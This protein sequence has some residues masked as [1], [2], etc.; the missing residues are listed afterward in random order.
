MFI[1]IH[2][3]LTGIYLCV[4]FGVTGRVD[5]NLLLIGILGGALIDLDKFIYFFIRKD[6]ISLKCRSAI[7]NME[8]QK[9]IKLVK[10][11]RKDIH[12]LFLHN[13]FFQTILAFLS[14]YFSFSGNL[15]LGIFFTSML[16]HTI[17]DI[18]DDFLVL[19]N[20]SNWLWVSK[21]KEIK[22]IYL[23]IYLLFIASCFIYSTLQIILH[24]S[25]LG[26]VNILHLSNLTLWIY[27]FFVTI[28]FM[29]PFLSFMSLYKF[30]K[31]NI[32][33]LI[34]LYLKHDS[35][36]ET[37]KNNIVLW[38][39][40]G[41]VLLFSILSLVGTSNEIYFF[42]VVVGVSAFFAIMIHPSVGQFVGVYGTSAVFIISALQQGSSWA[43]EHA[44]L[45]LIITAVAWVFSIVGGRIVYGMIK[46]SYSAFVIE[47]TA[48]NQSPKKIFNDLMLSKK[49]LK[50][51]YRKAHKETYNVKKDFRVAKFE[52][53]TTM[54]VCRTQGVCHMNCLI[55]F[56]ISDGYIPAL[57][58][59]GYIFWDQPPIFPRVRK[60]TKVDELMSGDYIYQKGKYMRVRD[61][62]SIDPFKLGEV[63][64]IDL[65]NEVISLFK[66]PSQVLDHF[67]N[68]R[69]SFDTDLYIYNISEI[70]KKDERFIV[71]GITH[72]HTS[73]KEYLTMESEIYSDTVLKEINAFLRS[74]EEKECIT[75]V[76]VLTGDNS[77]SVV[78]PKKSVYTHD[79]PIVY[80]ESNTDVRT[81][82]SL[83]DKVIPHKDKKVN[84]IKENVIFK[85]AVWLS[86]LFAAFILGT[87]GL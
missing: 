8:F 32:T 87:F 37:L 3:I 19:G 44:L 36:G 47:I 24:L 50:E 2:I 78:Y 14:V 29:F 77:I 76:E 42:M 63:D 59:L 51:A 73:T 75:K 83:I 33:S 17:C 48:K 56:K 45:F 53:N 86:E 34:N 80:Y 61:N 26:L 74:L 58:E 71:L 30:N 1:H 16:L 18:I 15:P 11:Y 35:W 22:S 28:F 85:I 69:A 84:W 5:W 43:H 7:F 10:K 82:M 41:S 12:N 13:V 31:R 38:I 60:T 55:R 57:K 49:C 9:L 27:L 21:S 66:T 81:A 54:E 39:L 40:M 64:V 4:I 68:T 6:P 46:M 52:D 23:L 62:E 72:E 65:K 70:N 20:M 67:L 25:G 79:N